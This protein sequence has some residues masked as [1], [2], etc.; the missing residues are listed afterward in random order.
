MLIFAVYT[1]SPM[2]YSE[3]QKQTWLTSNLRLAGLLA[4]LAV[5]LVVVS[6]VLCGIAF[7]FSGGIS[8]VVLLCAAVIGTFSGTL[9]VV[10]FMARKE[11]VFLEGSFVMVRTGPASLEKIP[12]DAVECFF[13][14]SQPLDRSGEP[15]VA[16]DADFRVGT[17]VV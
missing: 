11:R 13:L 3:T 10:A 6:L 17:L 15:V 1:I 2:T 16:D 12:L 4:G 14:G 8:L 5:F 7:R 9:G